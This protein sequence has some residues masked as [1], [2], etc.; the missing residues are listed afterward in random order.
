MTCHLNSAPFLCIN[1]H[2]IIA[3]HNPSSSSGPSIYHHPGLPL[4]TKNVV[5]SKTLTLTHPIIEPHALALN[6]TPFI[7]VAG[8][9]TVCPRTNP[10]SSPDGSSPGSSPDGSSPDGSRL[11]WCSGNGF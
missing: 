9:G 5:S 8:F 10:G 1:H 2:N 3:N 6:D 4:K 7:H 11:S